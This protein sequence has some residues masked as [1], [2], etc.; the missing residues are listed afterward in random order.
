MESIMARFGRKGNRLM[1]PAIPARAGVD[2]VDGVDRGAL[3][4]AGA[5]AA[6]HRLLF[7]RWL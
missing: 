3:G 6:P 1:D 7:R 4:A 2:F 5:A